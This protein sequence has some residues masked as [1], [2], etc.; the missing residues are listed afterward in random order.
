M[1]FAILL[2]LNF[3][4]SVIQ[5]NKSYPFHSLLPLSVKLSILQ[6]K[7]LL[8]VKT[9]LSCVKWCNKKKILAGYFQAKKKSMDRRIF[10]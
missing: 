8:V 9:Y 2:I 7:I 1:S 10:Y 4:L 5:I 6:E 3:L